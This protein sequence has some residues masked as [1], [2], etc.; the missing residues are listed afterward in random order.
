MRYHKAIETPA[1]AANTAYLETLASMEPVGGSGAATARGAETLRAGCRAA[2]GDASQMGS[3]AS[4]ASRADEKRRF[5]SR[6]VARANQASKPAGAGPSCDGTG[7]FDSSS[8]DSATARKPLP[9]NGLLPV[10]HSQAIT[11]RP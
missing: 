7:R 1:A 9:T 6:C 10:K 3:S 8:T 4:S 5:R 2:P 11:A